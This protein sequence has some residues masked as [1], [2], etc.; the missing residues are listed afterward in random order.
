ML[1]IVIFLVALSI[2]LPAAF[3]IM[4]VH[5]NVLIHRSSW[6]PQ[7]PW[8]EVSRTRMASRESP[9]DPEPPARGSPRDLAIGIDA[10]EIDGPVWAEPRD[11][12]GLRSSRADSGALALA[13][14]HSPRSS[15]RSSSATSNLVPSCSR[16]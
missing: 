10:S 16:A 11:R 3:G 8:S 13:K 6:Y 1:G 5:H 9:Q 14:R 12:G 2:M 4:L 7:Q 15:S